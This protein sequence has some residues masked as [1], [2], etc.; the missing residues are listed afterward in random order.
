MHNPKGTLIFVKICNNIEW[1]SILDI[2]TYLCQGYPGSE[3]RRHSRQVS[4]EC[5][6]VSIKHNYDQGIMKTN[7]WVASAT[8]N[9][10]TK[11]LS[12]IGNQPLTAH[13][14]QITWG[15]VLIRSGYSGQ[16]AHSKPWILQ[17]Q[18]CVGE[19]ILRGQHRC[20]H[21]GHRCTLGL[22]GSSL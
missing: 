17:P 10:M 21:D 19:V 20:G 6:W 1:L 2:K 14:E 5:R 7:K 16:C 9:E 4:L 12:L 11:A 3:F 15:H 13:R 22:Q 8:I 18:P